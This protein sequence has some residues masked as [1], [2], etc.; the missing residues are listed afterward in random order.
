MPSLKQG[1]SKMGPSMCRVYER[2]VHQNKPRARPLYIMAYTSDL[3][4]D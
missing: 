4:T 2:K 1:P 3:T